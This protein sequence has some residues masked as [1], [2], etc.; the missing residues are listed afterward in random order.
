ME[1]ILVTNNC[2]LFPAHF[3]FHF[4][5][6]PRIAGVFATQI[7]EGR[8]DAAG[9]AIQAAVHADV[10]F[11]RLAEILEQKFLADGG[12]DMLPR[13]DLVGAALTVGVERGVESM[14]LEGG[15]PGGILFA[16][17]PGIELRAVLPRG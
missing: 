9:V 7:D 3:W 15:Q 16:F 11:E 12:G 8:Q 13:K 6:F 5:T 1:R 4:G 10:T 17:V 2:Q 14:L